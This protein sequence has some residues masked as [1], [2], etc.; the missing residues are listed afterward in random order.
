[1]NDSSFDL[2]P[3]TTPIRQTP[4]YLRSVLLNSSCAK[5][6][7]Q[8]CC[9]LGTAWPES[10]L[11][12]NDIAESA[13]VSRATPPDADGGKRFCFNTASGKGSGDFLKR[14]PSKLRRIASK[15]SGQNTPA[16]LSRGDGHPFLARF[17]GRDGPDIFAIGVDSI[18]AIAAPPPRDNLFR[19]PS[20]LRIDYRQTLPDFSIHIHPHKLGM[21][22][23]DPRLS[24][25]WSTAIPVA[26]MI[27][28]FSFWPSR[29]SWTRL[30]LPS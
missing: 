11:N 19:V 28:S 14:A 13:G 24:R 2:P 25:L 27:I 18:E 1:M 4:L 16:M 3:T 15:I 21:V 6:G 8:H 20:Q 17:F 22:S 9:P 30:G 26:S 5:K 12:M 10:G 7:S 29:E 23:D